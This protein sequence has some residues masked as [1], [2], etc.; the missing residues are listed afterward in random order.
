MKILLV[1]PNYYTKYPPLGLM[2]LASYHRS[3]GNDIKLV[4]GNIKELSFKPD[5][6]EITSLFT[7]AWKPVHDAIYFYHQLFPFAKIRVGGIYASLM[8]D[9]IKSF[10]P[11]VDV[12]FGLFE[13]SEKYVP[14]YDILSNIDKWKNWDSSIVFTSRGCIRNCP[15]CAVPQLEGNF[16][17]VIDDIQKYI[18]PN[19]KKLILWDNNFLASPNWK[20]IMKKIKE[21]ELYVDFNQGLDAR[22]IDDE[23]AR[24]LV[25]LKTPLLRMAYDGN[26]GKKAIAKAVDLLSEYGFRKRNIFL[27]TLYNFYDEENRCGDNPDSFLTRIKDIVNLGCVS[28]P[29]RFEPLYSLDKNHFVSPLWNIEKL[30]MIAKARRVIGFGGAFPPYEGLVKKFISADTFNDAFSLYPIKEE[31]DDLKIHPLKKIAKRN[32]KILG[33]SNVLDW[34][35]DAPKQKIEL[36]R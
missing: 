10:F 25:D 14:A 21:T 12:N 28:Y 16:R 19:H 3:R 20:V 24:M 8:S 17:T 1:E 31:H 2:K 11:F 33:D 27:Y 34:R 5:N 29:M 7:Y 22:L 26:Y 4:R 15:F 30:E 32:D 13:D 35:I 23:K 9:R 18:Y 6:I 36:I